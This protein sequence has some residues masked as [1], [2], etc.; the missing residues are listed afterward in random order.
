MAGLTD[1]LIRPQDR[2]VSIVGGG[3]KTTLMYH[4]AHS[5]QAKGFRVISTSTTRILKPG[6]CHSEQL[7]FLKQKNFKM[8][9]EEGLEQFGHVTVVKEVIKGAK[10]QGLS[11]NEL[12]KMAAESSANYILVEADGAR[13]LPLKGAAEHEP[14]VSA[15]SDLFVAVI[16][17]DCIGKP[18]DDSHVFRSALVAERSGQ[19]PDSEIT[20]LTLAKFITHPLGALKG[21]PKRGRSAVLLNKTDIL[22]A[23][24]KAG[25]II[26][27]ARGM[28]GIQPSLWLTA[29]LLDAPSK[30]H[31]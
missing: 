4:L 27:L 3:G 23:R 17:L 21:C 20:P 28:G 24:E 15:K 13:R 9:L 8:L 19:L 5:L 16:G 6:P 25:E 26:A 2:I 22:G 31:K 10:L 1:R 29:S 7:L 11:R 12:E 14:V 30:C 18:L